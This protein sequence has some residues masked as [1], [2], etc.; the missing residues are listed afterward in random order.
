M[1]PTPNTMSAI[2]TS[3]GAILGVGD[4]AV[5]LLV[6]SDPE[7]LLPQPGGFEVFPNAN[8]EGREIPDSFSV[9]EA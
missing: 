2:S 5:Q 6:Q 7:P 9:A 1:T 3:T 4:A 8:T